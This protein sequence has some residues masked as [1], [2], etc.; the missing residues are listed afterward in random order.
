MRM[1]FVVRIIWS[2]PDEKSNVNASVLFPS[3]STKYIVP[4]EIP[5]LLLVLSERKLYIRSIS[6][7]G[8]EGIKDWMRVQFDKRRASLNYFL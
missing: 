2:K 4:L 3:A 7:S 6:S 1:L 8:R 5:T